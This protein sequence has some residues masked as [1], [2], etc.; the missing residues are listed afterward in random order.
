MKAFV[1]LTLASLSSVAFAEQATAS[2]QAQELDV[3]TYNYDM[4]LDVAHVVSITDT[5][6]ECGIVPTRMTYD[7]SQ[8]KRHIVEYMIWGNG[9]QEG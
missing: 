1:I 4:K 2:D 9:C 3:V 6:K 5:S 8:G 7:D